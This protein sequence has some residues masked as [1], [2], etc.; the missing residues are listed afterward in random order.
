MRTQARV[1]IWSLI[2]GVVAAFFVPQ[3]AA[4]AEEK[5]KPSFMEFVQGKGQEYIEG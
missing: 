5:A 4:A 3:F 2:L 1:L